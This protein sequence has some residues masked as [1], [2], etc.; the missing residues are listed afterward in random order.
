MGFRSVT[1]EPFGRE[2]IEQFVER[3]VK[4]LRSSDAEAAD[5]QI[6]QHRQVLTSAILASPSIRV[7]A[8]NPVMLTCLC[9]VHFNESK[10]REGRA[11]L[12]QAVIEWLLKARTA[13]REAAGYN[14]E[15]AR[16][17][18]ARLALGMMLTDQGKRSSIDFSDAVKLVRSELERQFPGETKEG[19]WRRGEAWL[20]FECEASGILQQLPGKQLRFWHL[21]FQEYL[22]AL[23]MSW[24]ASLAEDWWP[25]IRD[26]IDHPQ[27]RETIDVFPSCHLRWARAR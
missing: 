17:A 26:H 1:V 8:E 9:V 7:M 10:L 27:W 5:L 24:N 16:Q 15:F 21:T 4:G 18:F 6:E 11:R 2:E 14:N 13:Q 22:A 23:Q 19:L 12:Y 3:W 20:E 25:I